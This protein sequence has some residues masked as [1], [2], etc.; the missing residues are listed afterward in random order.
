M[1]N[2]KIL[3]MG[4]SI[5]ALNT[6]ERGWVGYF[7][8]IIKP[9]HFENVAV[10]GASWEDKSAT[11]YDGNPFFDHKDPK[12]Y[13]NVI[14][15]QV[16]KVLNNKAQGNAGFADFDLII[17]AAGTNWGDDITTEYI[18]RI[19]EQFFDN[20]DK[21]LPLDKVNRKTWAGAM[22]YA[23]EKL[24]AEYTNAVICYCSPIQ[25]A[26]DSRP[27]EIIR[28]KSTVMEEICK[29]ISDVTFIDTFLCGICGCYETRDQNGRDLIDGLHPN[30][31]GAKKIAKY[32]AN[33]IRRI[34]L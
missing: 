15:N 11:V 17:N 20:D 18:G 24:R 7:N 27:Y 33:A 12:M 13:N 28:A 23:Y 32:N 25:A 34:M 26:E 16:E 3:F 6:S 1:E 30:I 8:E 22:R 14:G 31:N 9:Q 10:S 5:T 2:L 19:K 29:R 21:P 4:D